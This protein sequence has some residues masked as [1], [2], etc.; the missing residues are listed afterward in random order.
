MKN[1]SCAAGIWGVRRGISGDLQVNYARGGGAF[2]LFFQGSFA[3]PH[4]PE[5][6]GGNTLTPA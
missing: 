2:G 5:V 1:L 3:I 6:G 4:I